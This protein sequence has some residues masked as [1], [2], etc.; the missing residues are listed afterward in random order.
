MPLPARSTGRAVIGQ[1]VAVGRQHADAAGGQRQNG[2]LL[3]DE[4]TRR[5]EASSMRTIQTPYFRWPTR[6]RDRGYF[7]RAVIPSSWNCRAV[8]ASQKVADASV[9]EFSVETPGGL[10][11]RPS[12]QRKI[13]SSCFCNGLEES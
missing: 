5:R 4:L 8:R 12:G 6:S 2:K 10:L 3:R 13:F 9:R 7:F 11:K 1:V